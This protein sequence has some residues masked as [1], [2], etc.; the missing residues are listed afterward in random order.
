MEKLE[1]TL[2]FIASID[3]RTDKQVLLRAFRLAG[4]Q[5]T[6]SEIMLEL[7]KTEPYRS[8]HSDSNIISIAA[9]HI[10]EKFHTISSSA[11]SRAIHFCLKNGQMPRNREVFDS[12]RNE[13]CAQLDERLGFSTAELQ[14]GERE[15]I[16]NAFVIS[17][18]H[19]TKEE[20][21]NE[22]IFQRKCNCLNR[23][24]HNQMILATIHVFQH[25]NKASCEDIARAFHFSEVEGR[26]PNLE[27]FNSPKL[28]SSATKYLYLLEDKVSTKACDCAICMESISPGDRVFEIPSCGHCFHSTPGDCLGQDTIKTW[29][30]THDSCPVCKTRVKIP[31]PS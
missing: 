1:H 19:S 23:I 8:L 13:Q 7:A 25:L 18:E 4:H 29:L 22:A 17:G 3:D 6:G 9:F 10:A 24:P 27:E 15:K 26:F 30:K 2:D 21:F 5:P 11:V 12:L 31:K 20:I 14:Y 28:N 16:L